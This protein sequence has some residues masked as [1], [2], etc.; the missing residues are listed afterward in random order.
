MVQKKRIP[1]GFNTISAYLVVPDCIEA[2][3]FYKRA[4]NAKQVLYIPGP[5]GKGTMHA[6]LRIG[7]SSIMLSDENPNWGQVS[8]ITMEGSP[9]SL[10]I[11][12]ED[13]D[14]LFK[15]ALDAGCQEVMPPDNSFWGDRYGKVKDPFG[16]EWGIAS[17]LE[18]L[19][20]DEVIERANRFMATGEM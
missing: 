19:S 8:A 20:R 10:H 1:E 3:A 2:I 4:F 18:T 11:Y 6:Q 9:V 12:T 14:T 17:Q 16:L 5:G 13:A 15:Q 7:D